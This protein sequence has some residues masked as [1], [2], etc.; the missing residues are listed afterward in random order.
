MMTPEFIKQKYL[1][2]LRQLGKEEWDV[3]NCLLINQIKGIPRSA[4]FCPIATYF[5]QKGECA[6]IGN[7][8]DK[9]G[10]IHRGVGVVDPYQRILF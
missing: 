2:I 9:D 5:N 6:A 4:N 8:L 7:E 1:D 10:L 3:F